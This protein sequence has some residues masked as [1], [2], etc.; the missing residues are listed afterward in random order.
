MKVLQVINSLT[1]G[2]AQKLIADFVPIMN[3][4]GVATD[5]LLFNED[6]GPFLEILFKKNVSVFNIKSKHLYSPFNVFKAAKYFDKYDIIHTHLFP[7]TYWT[8][9]AKMA[10]PVNRRAKYVLT[11]HSNSNGRF[12]KPYLRPVDKFIYSR[13]DALIAISE[14]VKEVLW[15]RTGHP[16]IPVIYNGVNIKELY[17]AQPVQLPRTEVNLLMVASF[18]A[19]K[20]QDTVIRAM[21]HLEDHYHLYLAGVG[22]GQKT[23]M[24][25]AKD[26][27]VEHRVHFMGMRKDIPGLMKSADI[28]ILS[29]HWEGL[30]CVTLEAMASGTPFI[31]TD[32]NGIKEMFTNN[33]F[34]LFKTGDVEALTQKIKRIAEDKPFALQQSELNLREV[35]KFDIEVMTDNYLELYKRLLQ[36]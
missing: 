4:K 36:S 10:R 3:E 15:N 13:F 22:S 9:L 31:G 28:N 20:D 8:S 16:D 30:S 26:L 6:K 29:S 11:E 34:A 14:S 25:L 2:G 32:V 24:Q 17:E 1:A 7:A 21:P 35:K 23:S 5:V 18:R 27:H 33:S 12:T 19:A